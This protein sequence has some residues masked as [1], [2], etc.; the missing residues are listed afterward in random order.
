MELAMFI[1]KSD[2]IEEMVLLLS[3]EYKKY[4]DKANQIVSTLLGS[5]IENIDYKA[6]EAVEL[7]IF[8]FIGL[9]LEKFRAENY[10][11]VLLKTNFNANEI[12]CRCNGIDRSQLQQMVDDNYADLSEVL[13]KSMVGQVC[14]SCMPEVKATCLASSH[15][16]DLYYG[17]SIGYWQEQINS[18]LK[19]LPKNLPVEYRNLHFEWINFKKGLLK[20]RCS[21]PREQL[22]RTDIQVVVRH[23]LQ[24]KL[25]AP[26]EVSIV[27]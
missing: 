22:S 27:F 2:S 12:I 21:G 13:K 10:L 6:H 17:K 20:L 3:G 24:G 5:K 15:A 16:A 4:Q 19:S 14:G 11:P 23:Q 26:I 8:E 9:A 25:Q 1:N 7:K 18:E